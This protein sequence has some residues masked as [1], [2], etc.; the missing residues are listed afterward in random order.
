MIANG[1]K[2][3]KKAEKKSKNNWLWKRK[4]EKTVGNNAS[5]SIVALQFK[6]LF[7][8]S[9]GLKNNG[10]KVAVARVGWAQ[11]RRALLTVRRNRR[12]LMNDFW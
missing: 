2:T 10:W 9:V 1:F 8:L 3:K 11:L 6:A 7:L 12:S 5:P 4:K